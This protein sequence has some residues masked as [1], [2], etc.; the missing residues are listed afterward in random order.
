MIEAVC[1]KSYED[2]TQKLKDNEA[3]I[4]RKRNELRQF[5]AEYRKV[6]VFFTNSWFKFV[7]RHL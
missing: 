6:I 1:A 7:W 2:T 5:E 3:Q 4:L